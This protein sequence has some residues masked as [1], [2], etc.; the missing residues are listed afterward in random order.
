MQNQECIVEWESCIESDLI[1]IFWNDGNLSARYWHN[2][3]KNKQIML[4]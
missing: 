4:Y 1:I 2:G 3:G